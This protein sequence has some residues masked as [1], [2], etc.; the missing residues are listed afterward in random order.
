MVYVVSTVNLYAAARNL[1]GSELDDFIEVATAGEPVDT[2]HEKV[3]VDVLDTQL[4]K[5]A[6][7]NIVKGDDANVVL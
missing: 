7:D 3:T 1:E 2:V 4:G 6:T 5:D